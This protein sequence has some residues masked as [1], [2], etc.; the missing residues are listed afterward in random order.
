M[1]NK[2]LL[3][4]KLIKLVKFLRTNQTNF[5]TSLKLTYT[6]FRFYDLFVRIIS[7]IKKYSN[8]YIK[9]GNIIIFKSIKSIGQIGQKYYIA[10]PLVV[11]T[12]GFIQISAKETRLGV[13]NLLTYNVF[14][15]EQSKYE[16]N[17]KRFYTTKSCN[18]NF[19]WRT[20]YIT[21]LNYLIRKSPSSNEIPNIEL[22]N[23]YLSITLTPFVQ[24]QKNQINYGLI[25]LKYDASKKNQFYFNKMQSIRVPIYINQKNSNIFDVI[26]LKF[27]GILPQMNKIH[28]VH[29][30]DEIDEIE[31]IEEYDE[32]QSAIDIIK[33]EEK[34][35]KDPLFDI[36][37]EKYKEKTTFFN[38]LKNMF[39]NFKNKKS[40]F[41]LKVNE[42]DDFLDFLK[43]I[44]LTQNKENKNYH[45]KIS[46]DSQNEEDDFE[47]YFEDEDLYMDKF[48]DA[49]DN[50]EDFFNYYRNFF[51]Y[52][53]EYTPFNPDAKSRLIPSK[54]KWFT[55]V[56]LNQDLADLVLHEESYLDLLELF[57]NLELSQLNTGLK[58]R[59]CSGYKYPD[60]KKVKNRI[61]VANGISRHN[62]LLNSIKIK[63]S[64]FQLFLEKNSNSTDKAICYPKSLNLSSAS[65]IEKKVIYQKLPSTYPKIDYPKID[66]PKIDY[67]KIDID[68]VF[69]KNFSELDWDFKFDQIIKSVYK[70]L[71][72]K[73]HPFKE[74]KESA[75]PLSWFF[76]FKIILS[77]GSFRILQL[78]YSDHGRDLVI[79]IINVLHW[80]G[81]VQDVE[82]VKE[83]LNLD[84]TI[85]KG[86]K[87]IRKIPKTNL[88]LA[89]VDSF[90][91]QFSSAFWY[92]KSKRIK[93]SRI[94][95]YWFDF[96]FKRNNSKM[97]APILLVGPPGSGKTVLIRAFAR[98]AN[99]PVLLQSGS[100]LQEYTK[101][102]RGVRSIRNLFRRARKISPCMIFIDEVDAIAARRKEMPTSSQ[103]EQNQDTLDRLDSFE[104]IEVSLHDLRTFYPK[105]SIKS[106]FV[107]EVKLEQ[108]DLI[109]FG[110]TIFE[111]R[112]RKINAHRIKVLQQ[113][114][115]ESRTRIEQLAMLTQLLI[116]LDGLNT[117][118][119]MLVMSATN[120]LF[121]IDPAL[122]RPGRFYKVLNLG[123]PDTT[124][125]IQILQLCSSF[126]G[127][128][129]KTA[130]YWH[131]LSR[132]ME[133]LTTSDIASITRQS[134]LIAVSK[135]QLH[136][137]E[138]FDKAIERVITYSSKIDLVYYYRLLYIAI[139]QTKHRFLINN[140]FK[141]SYKINSKT[142]ILVKKK[143]NTIFTD[144]TSVNRLRFFTIAQRLAYYESAKSIIQIIL[145][146]HPSS[147][148]LEIQHRRKT[149]RYLSGQ[150]MLLKLF[151]TEPF[152][153]K[154]EQRLIG[155]LA[156]KTGELFY[157]YS[158]IKPHLKNIFKLLPLKDYKVFNE[159][160][161]EQDELKSATLLAFIM[162]EKWYF[163]VE[164]ISAYYF[165][166]LYGNLN[167]KEL[168]EQTRRIFK[169][170]FEEMAAEINF[171]NR[172]IFGGQKW[173]YKTWWVKDLVNKE[174]FFEKGSLVD[175][176][177]IYCSKVEESEENIEWVPPDDYYNTSNLRSKDSFIIWEKFLKITYEYLYSGLLLNCININF[178][179][180]S[181]HRELMD[182]LSDCVMR[183]K[184]IRIF[185]FKDLMDPFLIKQTKFTQSEDDN[186]EKFIFL[187]SWGSSSRR[188]VSFFADLEKIRQNQ[189]EKEEKKKSSN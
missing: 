120:R 80:F 182:Y 62:S 52:D 47:Y 106:L 162:I 96:K 185:R 101:S 122:L 152:R 170:V 19:D 30:I 146:L 143:N 111:S 42:D 24:N 34:D 180:L 7:K 179:I 82:W 119:D 68:F 36:E 186:L 105:S 112:D 154:I 117:I 59:F 51:Y 129:V 188:S 159:S 130:S 29:I 124:K 71:L 145:P 97:L 12:I 6:F 72:S 18:L 48:L 174:T 28:E 138:S 123:F 125:R 107:E 98:E 77:L 86:Y 57:D 133:G 79:T 64:F 155:F 108:D 110:E 94:F 175:W 53:D 144:L 148:F 140:L 90:F 74:I 183:N 173:S 150:G 33:I 113:M 93:F 14:I 147:V 116:E 176:Y 17:W 76:V 2:N 73:N 99:L 5:L 31:E 132:R 44:K 181:N 60:I 66:Y 131:Y 165:H 91:I 83:E 37:D 187:K 35:I 8:Q 135:G 115:I 134:A 157:G 58:P 55:C 164:Q 95:D 61:T 109:L 118:N 3:E 70:F 50:R 114:Q 102:A 26:P 38:I 100:I 1:K 141:K 103:L 153:S 172:I 160:N 92:L 161:I 32:L 20:F 63:K 13:F 177:R 184:K 43:E 27:E 9:F 128:K 84:N 11:F 15:K 163:Y 65:I 25:P 78:V 85:A 104:H 54:L 45:K 156:G 167:N 40:K 23:K 87:A 81:V 88:P 10:I 169:E 4:K 151:Q 121:A 149:N 168:D 75:G 166:S 49:V 22:F 89:G 136:N 127:N 16:D 21:D 46:E 139:F 126:V 56:L 189:L 178:S 41:L 142:K 39:E 137:V 158:A 171:K 69:L 67:P